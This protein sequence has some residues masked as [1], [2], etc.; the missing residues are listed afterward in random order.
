MMV[1]AGTNSLAALLSLSL[2]C[3]QAL[4]FTG[5]VAP[6]RFTSTSGLSRTSSSPQS[7]STSTSLQQQRWQHSN[8]WLSGRRTGGVAGAS[9]VASLRMSETA[10][11]AGAAVEEGAERFE[12]QAEVG[13]V[14]D[15]I[16]NSLYSNRD[17]FLRELISNA[18]DACDKKRFLAVTEQSEEGAYSDP[19]YRIRI[20]A[21]KVRSVH[22]PMFV[23]ITGWADVRL[24]SRWQ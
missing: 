10:E 8:A 17:V 15:I 4:A 16:I 21:D 1:P 2:A 11:A 7:A 24:I 19:E 6:S 23:H 13:R 22:P 14:M 20:R 18:A 12:F 5:G 9:R 3:Y